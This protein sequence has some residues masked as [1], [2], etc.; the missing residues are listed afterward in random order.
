M[1]VNFMEKRES[2]VDVL[3]RKSFESVSEGDVVILP[4]FGATIEEMQLLDEK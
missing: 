2:A 3:N 1:D 4:A